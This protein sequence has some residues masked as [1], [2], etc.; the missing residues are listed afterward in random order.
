MENV[1][2]KINL[3]SF[4]VLRQ[5]S[6]FKNDPKSDI[7]SSTIKEICSSVRVTIW[8]EQSND[9]W[10]E[11]VKYRGWFPS[12]KEA[13]KDDNHLLIRFKNQLS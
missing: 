4:R 13:D 9:T 3:K 8:F 6:K 12:K 10:M 2:V 5:C 11:V 7:A 1:F